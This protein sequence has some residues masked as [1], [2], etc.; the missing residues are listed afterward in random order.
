MVVDLIRD[1]S[2]DASQE[3]DL[4]DQT[5]DL[6]DQTTDILDHSTDLLDHSTDLLDHSIDLLDHSTTDRSAD[7]P[8]D[9]QTIQGTESDKIYK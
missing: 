1:P 9:G 5:T 2:E 3:D 6:L 8:L 4:M 7:L